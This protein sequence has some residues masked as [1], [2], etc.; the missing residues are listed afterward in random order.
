[1]EMDVSTTRDQSVDTQP[2]GRC[3]LSSLLSGLRSHDSLEAIVFL[4]FEELDKLFRQHL[5]KLAHEIAVTGNATIQIAD[6]AS[7]FMDAAA[8]IDRAKD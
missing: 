5:S 3:C 6:S 1:M 2:G 4:W 8:K 7:K